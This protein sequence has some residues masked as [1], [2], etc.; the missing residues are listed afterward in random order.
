MPEAAGL[1]MLALKT[2]SPPP[3]SNTSP[4][5]NTNLLTHSVTLLLLLTPYLQSESAPAPLT[6]G[7]LLSI[8][9][10]LPGHR[11]PQQVYNQR[12]SRAGR[13]WAVV[14]V[15]C[16]RQAACA[17]H[18]LLLLLLPI[19]PAAQPAPCCPKPPFLS[20]ALHGQAFQSCL[21]SQILCFF[22]EEAAIHRVGILCKNKVGTYAVYLGS[23]QPPAFLSW[24]TLDRNSNIL[25]I[26]ETSLAR[27]HPYFQMSS[28]DDTLP[29]VVIHSC[30]IWWLVWQWIL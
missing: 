19:L 5:L 3:V 23:W 4:I 12:S 26:P 28:D 8:Q 15:V 7:H 17:Q 6:A 10:L 11:R 29:L 14:L 30:I 25:V 9:L 13:Y 2:W 20:R 22:I 24:S 18:P 16:P 21:L 1:L 27:F